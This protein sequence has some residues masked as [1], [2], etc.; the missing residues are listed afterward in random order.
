MN[1][2]HPEVTGYEALYRSMMKCKKGVM[3][4]DSTA[5]FCLNGLTEVM[6]LEQSLMDGTYKERPGR[7]FTVYEPKRREILSI[8]FRDRIYQRS[9]ND[10]AVYPMM[11]K[12]FIYDNCACQQGKGADFAMNRLN[13]HLQRYYRKHGKDGWVLQC[14]IKG[15]YPNMP[16][17]VAEKKFAKHLDEWTFAEVKKILDRFEGDI[18]FNPGSQLIQIAGISVLDE[19]DHF[20][21]EK[22]RVRHYL[23]YMDDFLLISDDKEFLRNCLENIKEYLKERGFELNEKT[24]LYRISQGIKFL[25]FRFILTDTGKV[26][27]L[28]KTESVK[29]ERKKLRK[30]VRLA[31][32]G[33]LT[34][35]K[36]DQ[37]YES[38]KA[39][40]RRGNTWKML[41]RLDKFYEE[42]WK[43]D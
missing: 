13:A 32:K 41:R 20:V 12:S 25:G 37:C 5:H 33:K 11:A 9:L 21:K 18:G 39:H 40:V 26:I 7:I 16:H 14:D 10:N 35:E 43:E 36:V 38:Y 15:Y 31:K 22:L 23:R 6:K 28:I 19:M 29:R 17:E 1:N 42:L 2:E 27:R 24:S 30:L 3:W 8:S 4:K 34:R